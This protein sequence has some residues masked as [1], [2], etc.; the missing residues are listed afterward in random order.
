MLTGDAA[1]LADPIFH[2]G[3]GQA[4]FSGKIA[5]ECI[6]NKEIELYEKKINSMSFSSNNLSKASEILYSLDNRVLNELGDILEGKG[7]SYIKTFAG[8]LKVLSKPRLLK[9]IGKFFIFFSAI[10]NNKDFI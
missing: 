3:I 1:G 9:N 7:F 6:L 2:G 8:I 10:K 4:M 5:A